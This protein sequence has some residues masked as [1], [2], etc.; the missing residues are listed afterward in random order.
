MVLFSL[1]F[2]QDN[3]KMNITQVFEIFKIIKAMKNI[4]IHNDTEDLGF[5]DNSSVSDSLTA[6]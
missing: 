1:W 5:I 2:L 3:P 4:L 6:R